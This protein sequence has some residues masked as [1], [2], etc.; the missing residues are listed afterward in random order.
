[1]NSIMV[2]TATSNGEAIK[3]ITYRSNCDKLWPSI[4]QFAML[5]IGTVVSLIDR[6]EPRL[7]GAPGRQIVWR[8]LN[9]YSARFFGLG[10]D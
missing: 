9:R 2:I 5:Q 3:C 7:V 6:A 4:W 10:K 8:P 1:M